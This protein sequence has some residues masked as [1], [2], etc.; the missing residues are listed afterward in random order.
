M[1]QDQRAFAAA[2]SQVLT[3]AV[4]DS[5]VSLIGSL[6]AG[7]ADAY[8]DVDL[9]W[10]VP[11]GSVPTCVE[12]LPSV[13]G[14]VAEFVSVRSSPEFQRSAVRRS[15][16]VRFR[17]VPLFWRL[18]LAV[19]AASHAF[20]ESADIDNPEARGADWSL[21]ESAA[22][23]AIGARKE[24]LR[25]RS[26]LADGLLSRGFQRIDAPDPGGDW[27]TRIT[28]LARAAASR[29]PNSTISAT[30][31]STWQPTST[32]RPIPPPHKRSPGSAYCRVTTVSIET[33]I[34]RAWDLQF[35]LKL[36]FRRSRGS[37]ASGSVLV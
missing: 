35:Q 7:T 32:D 3:S 26:S 2:I 5:R 16:F 11:E 30:R 37:R 14:T 4:S 21:P 28:S 6:G 31:S 1:F 36:W 22:M 10:V 33:V 18:D 29:A 15:V 34:P 9:A 8:S 27:H 17:R 19:W 24:V 23:N 13:L 12:R 20:D 25:G